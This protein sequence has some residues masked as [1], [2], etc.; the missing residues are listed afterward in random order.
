MEQVIDVARTMRERSMAHHLSGTVKEILG[1]CQ[2]IG[3]T[4]DKAHPHDKIDEINSGEITI[5]VSSQNMLTKYLPNTLSSI[6]RV[7]YGLTI[8]IVNY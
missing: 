6:G 7:N 1:T 4:V 5:P 8:I 3:C 2:S